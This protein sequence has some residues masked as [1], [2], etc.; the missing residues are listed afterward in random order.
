MNSAWPAVIGSISG[1]VLVGIPAL[2]GAYWT[3]QSHKAQLEAQVEQIRLQIRA[4]G[5]EQRR[6]PRSHHYAEFVNGIDVL[7]EY[8]HDH[9]LGTRMP[10]DADE[11]AEVREEVRRQERELHR[12][13]SRVA[14][15]GTISVVNAGVEALDA[16]GEITKCLG[17]DLRG[18]R[19]DPPEDVTPRL[20]RREL[21]D[22]VDNAHATFI[23]AA[24]RSLQDDGVRRVRRTVPN[25]S[26]IRAEDTHDD[27][28]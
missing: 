27:P 25:A 18:R 8:L 22:A 2:I 10:A 26:P 11:L 14:V 12:T 24:R 20:T 19:A 5:L 9:W 28:T 6:E 13:W 21:W 7:L 3:K 1:G 17:S 4:Q 23:T 16:I 15:E